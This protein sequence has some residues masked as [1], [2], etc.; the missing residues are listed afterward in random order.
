MKIIENENDDAMAFENTPLHILCHYYK[1]ETRNENLINLIKLLIEKGAEVNATDRLGSTPLH[2]LCRYYHESKENLVT[3]V[4]LFTEKDNDVIN[5]RD[6]N[7]WTLL[8]W[9]CYSYKTNKSGDEIMNKKEDLMGLVDF[10][11]GMG[12]DSSARNKF[13]STPIYLI[14]QRGI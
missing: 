9:L 14:R 11:V 6:K 7:G 8:H 10:F 5:A 12:A 13:G 2:W 1:N 3:M 4:R